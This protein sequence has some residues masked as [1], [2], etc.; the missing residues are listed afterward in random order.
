[1]ATAQMI[2]PKKQEQDQQQGEWTSIFPPDVA[3]ELQSTLFVKKL[4][5]VAVSTV[6]Y[7]RALFPEDAF[8]DRC[9]E[10][11]RLKILRDD[12]DFPEA[13]KVI[14]WLR[15]CFDALHKKYLRAVLIGIYENPDDPNT[16]VEEYSFKFSY[17]DGKG[18]DIYRNGSKISSNSFSEDEGKLDAEVKRSTVRLLQTIVMLS[19]T[20]ESLP[21]KVKK[22]LSVLSF[23]FLVQEAS[24]VSLSAY[25]SHFVPNKFEMCKKIN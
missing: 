2:R 11:V 16:V 12:A 20:L 21:E 10:D 1:M 22:F 14:Q 18:M 8:G 4:L 3:T 6:S 15:G 5:A 23:Q 24:S 9:L 7:L 13:R 19:N 25:P 17:G